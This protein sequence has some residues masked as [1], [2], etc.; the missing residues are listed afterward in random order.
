MTTTTATPRTNAKIDPR[1]RARRVAVQRGEGRRRLR[2]LVVLIVAVASLALGY[3]ITRSPLLDV[4]H[5]RVEGTVHTDPGRLLD[6]AGVRRG[7]A[8]TDV[9]LRRAEQAI[10]ALPWVDTVH[11]RRHWPGSIDIRVTERAAVAALQPVINGTPW[12]LLDRTGRV[13]DQSVTAPPDLP[14]ISGVPATA[15]PG[16][17][18]SGVSN[19]LAVVSL[20]TP[21]LRAWLVAVEVGGDGAASLALRGDIRVDFGSQAHL[22]D[23]M[24]DL[25]TVLTR[26]DLADLAGV[27]LSVV[28]TPVLTRKA[29][30]A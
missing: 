24:V 16:A 8:M 26:V 3:T 18:E 28:H 19:A 2:R 30:P 13:L 11:V 15:E 4:D 7:T 6:V 10:A 22:A 12:S 21:D 27:D 5:V 23:K 20:L 14:R 9:D 17:T 25:A 29:P 1:M